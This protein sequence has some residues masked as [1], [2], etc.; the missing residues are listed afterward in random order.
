MYTDNMKIAIVAPPWIAIPPLGY[1][2]TESVVYNVAEGLVKKGH[3]VTLYATGESHFSSR[4]EYFY[5]KALGNNLDLKLNPFYILNHLHHFYKSADNRFDI[6][7]DNASDMMLSIYFA[8]LIK[9]PTVFTM[10]G[11]FINNPKD[12]FSKYQIMTSIRNTL[13]DFKNLNFVSLS[14]AHRTIIPELNYVKTVYNGIQLHDFAFNETGAENIIWIGRV[15]ATKGPDIA[16]SV[17]AQLKKEIVMGGYIDSGDLAYYETKIKPLTGEIQ[18]VKGVD[19]KSAFFGKA[20]VYLFPIQYEDTCPLTP[21]ESMSCGT[22]VVTF[23]RGAMPEQMQDGKTGYIINPSDDDIRGDWIIKKTGIDGLREAI[24][25]IY[26]MP[27]KEY[28]EMR[29]FCRKHIEQNFSVDRMV[30][31]YEKVYEQ[32]LNTK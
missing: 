10:H 14:D 29:K 23:A 19:E 11:T 17:A 16:F 27:E 21:L 32:I 3:E 26:Q 28:R 25:R 2:G 9:T 4:L 22:P 15:N 12:P 7:H 8:S 5:P 20:K 30:N 6:I 18:E 1:G 24:E 13:I 31:E